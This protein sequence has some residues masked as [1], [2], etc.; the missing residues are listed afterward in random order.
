MAKKVSAVKLFS[1]SAVARRTG[2]AESTVRRLADTGVVECERDSANRRVFRQG[3]VDTLL[4]RAANPASQYNRE[5]R[6]T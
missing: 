4:R 2:F 3:A 5:P 6:A 1:A